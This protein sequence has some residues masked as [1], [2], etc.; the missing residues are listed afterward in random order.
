M[1]YIAP[2]SIIRIYKNIPLDNTYEDTIY[3]ASASAQRSYFNTG[4]QYTL[5]DHSYQRVNNNQG[6]IKVEIL[7][8]NLYTCNYMAFQNTN[9]GNKWFYAFITNVEYINNATSLVTFEIDDMQTYMFDYE[10]LQCFVERE[11]SATDEAGDNIVEENLDIGDYQYSDIKHSG[12]FDDWGVLVQSNYNFEGQQSYDGMFSQVGDM[13]IGTDVFLCTEY[14]GHDIPSQLQEWI[15]TVTNAYG[16]DG[17]NILSISMFP[18]ELYDTIDTPQHFIV[19]KPTKNGTY[20]PKNKKLLTYPYCYLGLTNGTGEINEYRYEYFNTASCRFQVRGDLTSV[21]AIASPIGYNTDSGLSY[22]NHNFATFMN[23]FPQCNFTIDS[24]KMW[25]AQNKVTT[26]TNVGLGIAGYV[27]GA[28]AAATGHL[29]A[30]KAVMTASKARIA[31][32]LADYNQREGL[33]DYMQGVAGSGV[34]VNTGMQDFCHIN[35]HLQPS[36]AR[37]IDDYFSLYGYATHRVKVPNRNVRPHWTYTKT[38][39]CKIIGN[40]PTNVAKHICEIYDKG[41]TFWKN[42]S[43]VGNYAVDNTIS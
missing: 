4:I 5:D 40:C 19:Q 27:G 41:I 20:T 22:P 11:H 25:W 39:G 35:I 28:A 15:T 7:A 34:M 36:Y 29:V 2:N 12:L 21:S 38:I 16:E 43:E 23:N 37:I 30:G 26:A 32:I 13:I 42:P 31:S 1:A 8:D 17:S 14:D 10:L 3:F 9:F 24:F 33:K 18:T 6:Q